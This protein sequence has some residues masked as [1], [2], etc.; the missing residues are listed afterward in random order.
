MMLTGHPERT[1][2]KPTFILLLTVI[3]PATT[4]ALHAQGE[5]PSPAATAAPV[6]YEPLPT[7]NAS[8]IL[9][10]QYFQGPNF[11]VRNPVPTYSG[12]NHYTIDSDFGVF[13]ADGN[14]MLVRRVAEIN[15]IA[16]LQAMS[17]TKEF[18]QAAKQAAEVPL[19]VARNLVTN[20]VSTI[21]SVPR[22]I[23]G[24]LNQ[25]GQAVKEAAEGR[26][27]TA[28]CRAAR[29]WRF[30]RTGLGESSTSAASCLVSRA[31]RR[32]GAGRHPIRRCQSIGQAS[33]HN[34]EACPG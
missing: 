11:T 21:S 9:Q 15:A 5:S 23:W 1:Y 2:M 17:Q 30:R 24:F 19:N 34:G 22:G 13:E 3:I 16:K 10:P 4:V 6:V 7:L 33:D 27:S 14:A 26:Q 28:A 25:A 18:T 20:P 31:V 32:S 29:W 8:E 12:S